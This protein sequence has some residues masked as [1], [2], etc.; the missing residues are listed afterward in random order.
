MATLTLLCTLSVLFAPTTARADLGDDMADLF[1]TALNGLKGT[2]IEPVTIRFAYKPPDFDQPPLPP[3]EFDSVHVAVTFIGFAF[4]DPPDPWVEPSDVPIPPLNA[5]GCTN[6]A[7]V[8]ADVNPTLTSAEYVVTVSDLFLDL[9][10]TRDETE[11]CLEFGGGEVTSDAYLVLEVTFRFATT[12]ELVGTCLQA[13]LVPGSLFIEME[14]KK[15]G[16]KDDDCLTAAW[17]LFGPVFLDFL[18]QAAGLALE[19]AVISLMDDFNEALCLITPAEPL[20]W[21]SLKQL[22]Q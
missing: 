13:S 22:Y 19:G 8:V 4:C 18:G 14:E 7:T 2:E 10:Y 12:M 1:E 11:A 20:T 16:F 21:G 6:V 3:V 5:Y 17:P 9:V 15:H